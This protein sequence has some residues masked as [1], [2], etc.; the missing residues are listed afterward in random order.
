[1]L[2]ES[3][4]YLI[5]EVGYHPDKGR[6]LLLPLCTLTKLPVAA[7]LKCVNLVN[8]LGANSMED[9]ADQ[10]ETEKEM[11][12]TNVLSEMYKVEAQLQ[13]FIE[14]D[15]NIS[16]TDLVDV[17]SKAALLI[18]I[19]SQVKTLTVLEQL[20]D[21]AATFLSSNND[22][23]KKCLSSM[24][25]T[26][27]QSKEHKNKD[28]IVNFIV[29]VVKI[30]GSEAGITSYADET[31]CADEEMF[32]KLVCQLHL[33]QSYQHVCQIITSLSSVEDSTLA[34]MIRCDL[35]GKLASS[36]LYMRL[37]EV[38][39]CY[40]LTDNLIDQLKESGFI[41]LAYSLQLSSMRVPSA[42]RTMS[43]FKLNFK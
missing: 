22:V 24:I 19:A 3:I 33:T 12:N 25:S 23:L 31:R 39:Q 21:F 28:E 8:L 37:V 36:D 34:S 17:E 14:E 41:A 20:A 9:I 30:L 29:K 38:A 35:G 10:N 4:E 11:L 2:I 43:A 1:V 18:N 42:L 7:R 40:G 13:E 15:V 26:T 5:Q 27:L 16:E 32:V 6:E